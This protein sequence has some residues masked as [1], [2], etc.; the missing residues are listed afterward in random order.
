MQ[1]VSYY[2][3]EQDQ[4]AIL[5]DGLLYDTDLMHPGLPVSMGVFLNYWEDVYPV[6]IE[7]DKIIKEGRVSAKQG[8]NI[9][10]VTVLCPVP[11]PVSL[12]DAYA[13]RQHVNMTRQEPDAAMI[14]EFDKFPVFYFSNHTSIQGPG[15]INCMLDH[16]QKLDFEL[17]VAIVICKPGKNIKAEEADEYIG[18]LMIMNDV[19]ARQLQ[20]EEMKLNLGPAKGKDFCTAIGPMLVTPDALEPFLVDPPEGHVG[21]AYDLKMTCKINDIEVSS[22]NLKDMA[23]TFAEIIER[24]SYG[25][26]LFPGDIIGSGTVGTGCFLELNISG[27]LNNTTYQEQWLKEGDVIT[28]EVE[29]LGS[30]VNTVV[31]DESDFSLLALKK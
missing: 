25:V 17:E 6:A 14:A 22:G 12:R 1:L 28:L 8:I 13:F 7:V 23:W 9:D 26:Q 18:G 29:Q 21:N 20:L 24:C 5:V 31:K 4:L 27:K 3:D 2:K 10:D 16:L 19:S 11:H 15:D 30:L